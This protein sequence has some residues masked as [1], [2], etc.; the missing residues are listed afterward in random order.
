MHQKKSKR[1]G[2]KNRSS[3]KHEWQLRRVMLARAKALPIE[4]DV[5]DYE[6]AKGVE[7]SALK[8]YF[9]LTKFINKKL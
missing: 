3:G 5:S 2:R 6:Q 7:E 9:Y 1:E 4:C 8:Q